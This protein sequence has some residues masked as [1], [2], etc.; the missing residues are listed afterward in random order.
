MGNLQIQLLKQTK[1]KDI[2]VYELMVKTKTE[3]I[4]NLEKMMNSY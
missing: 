1:D 4:N 3:T 2:E